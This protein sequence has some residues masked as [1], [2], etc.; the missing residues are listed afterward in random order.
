VNYDIFFLIIAINIFQLASIP[1]LDVDLVVESAPIV[2]ST[3]QPPD[4][5][6]NTQNLVNHHQV[7]DSEPPEKSIGATATIT[8]VVADDNTEPDPN[9]TKFFKMV[10][11]GVPPQ[12]VKL[13]M[14]SE[15]LNPDFLE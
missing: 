4:T 6:N 3:P 12:A 13:K 9:Y 5:E 2:I 14:Q 8:E 7:D 10:Q 11:F 15:G 1:G